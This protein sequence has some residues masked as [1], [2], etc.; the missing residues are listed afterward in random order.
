MKSVF[1]LAAVAALAMFAGSASA[2]EK[3]SGKLQLKGTYEIVAGE[4][5]GKELPAEHFKGA[6]VIFTETEVAGTDSKKK[7]LFTADYELDESS[8]PYKLK[9]TSKEKGKV[10]TTTG[11]LE[12][13]EGIVKLTYALPGGD[14]PTDF[15]TK[16]GQMFFTLKKVK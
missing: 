8:K 14:P 9:M 16:Q 1:T 4:R 2:E 3:K 5:D 13:K 12:V 10:S 11:L 15:A 7:E 6:V